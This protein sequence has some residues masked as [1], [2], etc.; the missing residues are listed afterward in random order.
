MANSTWRR[1]ETLFIQWG[2]LFISSLLITGCQLY[3]NNHAMQIPYVL[4]LQDSS[5]FPGDP[6]V[7]TFPKYVGPVWHLIAFLSEYI[8]LEST[9]FISFLITRGLIILAPAFVANSIF[10][11]SRLAQVGAM[12]FFALAPAPIIGHGTLVINYF[13][14]TGLSVAF[15]L[16]AIAA[17]YSKRSFLWAILLAIGFNLNLLYGTYA[18]VFFIPVM[19]VDS[20]YRKSWK[21]W[22]TA[23]V[24][25][26]ILSAPIVIFSV[27]NIQL[28]SAL[29]ELW[30]KAGEVR[31]PFHI[32]P[33]TWNIRQIVVFTGFMLFYCLV[34]FFSR[35][36]IPRLFKQ[37]LIWFIVCLCWIGLAF[38][39]AYIFQSPNLLIIQPA[40]AS[41]IW[42]AFAAIQV[43][44]VFAC[45]I[46][47]ERKLSRLGTV[48]FFIGVFWL[49][50]FYF[51]IIT[52]SVWFVTAVVVA[53]PGAWAFLNRN[54]GPLIISNA[55]VIIVAAFG[56]L[57]LIEDMGS[58]IENGLVKLPDAEMRKIASWAKE[59]TTKEDKF[60]VDPNWEEFRPISQRSVFVAWKD[61]TAIFWDRS[62]VEK[63]VER[64]ERFGFVF[65]T[66]KLGTTRGSSELSKHYLK[67]D[68]A[69]VLE[70]SNDYHLQ[71][72]V[73][74]LDKDSAFPE[75]YRTRDHKI[76]KIQ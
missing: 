32:Y 65:T 57:N 55:V 52:A 67:M 16:L 46:E 53:I 13:E 36:R 11:G 30:L 71:Y 22:G 5:L 58:Y 59:N 33:H 76:L 9:L 47:E 74:K 15:L 44:A 73:V 17:F 40:R 18:L 34:L 21:K 1:W 39:G 4:W 37:G 31:H 27:P 24:I 7:S 43:I 50:F 60:L 25:F 54:K 48:L 6:L 63:W 70:L 75:V 23:L 2:I 12:A 56:I 20:Q 41:D 8:P 61:G 62:F 45:W 19:L 10:P 38:F 66:A 69:D 28:D 29:E 35:D 68:D 51:P 49:N 42:F 3:S 26:L 64:I 14:H 72:W